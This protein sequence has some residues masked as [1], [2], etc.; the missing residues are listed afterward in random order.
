MSWPV[1]ATPHIRER[2]IFLQSRAGKELVYLRKPRSKV[3]FAAYLGLLGVSVGGSVFQLIQYARG[4]A[5][6]E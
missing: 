5:K 2:Q 3:Y 6:K 4:H 1:T